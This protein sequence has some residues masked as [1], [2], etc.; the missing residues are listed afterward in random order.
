MKRLI[1]RDE[2]VERK[3]VPIYDNSLE[4]IQLKNK[5]PEGRVV[6]MCGENRSEDSR[7]MAFGFS[8][9]REDEWEQVY[10]LTR[11][12]PVLEFDKLNGNNPEDSETYVYTYHDS[13]FRRGNSQLRPGHLL[14]EV[15]IQ[16][17]MP[18]CLYGLSKDC[19][20][21]YHEQS[22]SYVYRHVFARVPYYKKHVEDI[23]RELI[24][25]QS[26]VEDNEKRK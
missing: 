14:Y 3:S 26:N 21:A 8:E 18:I 11:K 24:K 7:F 19:G 10:S 6:K 4:V 15:D 22:N 12:F 17:G 25:S 5:Q 13:C 9:S 1:L 23:K 20:R 16:T 2:M